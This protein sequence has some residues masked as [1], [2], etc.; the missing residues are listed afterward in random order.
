MPDIDDFTAAEMLDCGMRDADDERAQARG[1]VKVAHEEACV[2]CVCFV[3]QL[4][5]GH[6]RAGLRFAQSRVLR[7]SVCESK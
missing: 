4:R 5:D 3:M 1:R 7:P 2:W 6:G